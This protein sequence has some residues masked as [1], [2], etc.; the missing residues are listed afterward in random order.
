MRGAGFFI[1]RTEWDRAALAAVNPLATYYH[2]DEF[3]RP[4]FAAVRW[5]PEAHDG[6]TVYTTSSAL[7]GKGTECLLEA[8]AIM[9]RRAGRT[10]ALR[11]AGVYPGSE[12]DG[13]YRR[14]AERLGIAGQVIWLGRIG[15]AALARELETADVFAYPSHVDNSPNSVAEAML[16]GAPIVAANVAA[17][18]S[19]ARREGG[20]PDPAGRCRRSCRRGHAAPG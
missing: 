2:C 9:K 10:V 8:A 18:S 3:M 4:E 6:D 14:V 15:A 7:M 13:I 20:H 19:R 11:I 1:G 17:S 5:M 12:L 16:V